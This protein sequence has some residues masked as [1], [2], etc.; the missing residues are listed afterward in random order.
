MDLLPLQK[1]IEASNEAPAPVFIANRI[2]GFLSV[3]PMVHI[4]CFNRPMRVSRDITRC[5]VRARS[6][7][8]GKGPRGS[9]NIEAKVHI[10]I[11][12]CR[13]ILETSLT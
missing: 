6:T 9:L 11:N 5:E 2:F 10:G 13:D 1:A 3:N 4:L 7:I 8:T 12:E